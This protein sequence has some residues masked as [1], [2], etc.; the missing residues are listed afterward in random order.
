MALDAL[1]ARLEG[2]A[3]TSVTADAIPNVTPKPASIKACTPVT[4][5]TA[6][7]DDTAELRALVN[8]VADHHGFTTEQRREA[9]EI[10]LADSTAALECFRGLAAGVSPRP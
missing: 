7:N 1:L 4:S 2:R 9:L 8:R 6:E 10:A 3:V 5:V